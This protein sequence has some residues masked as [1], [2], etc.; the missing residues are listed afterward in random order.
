MDTELVSKSYNEFEELYQQFRLIVSNWITSHKAGSEIRKGIEDI[1]FNPNLPDYE[2][3]K[4]LYLFI[5]SVFLSWFH[6]GEKRET[7]S[8]AYYKIAE[9]YEAFDLPMEQQEKVLEQQQKVLQQQQLQQQEDQKRQEELQKHLEQLNQ[10][11]ILPQA[12][13]DDEEQL[14]SRTKQGR[15]QRQREQ[16]ERQQQMQLQFQQQQ[17]EQQ[18]LQI[19]QQNKQIQKQ[20]EFQKQQTLQEQQEQ[21]RQQAIQTQFQQQLKQVPIPMA[22]QQLEFDQRIPFNSL[23]KGFTAGSVLTPKETPKVSFSKSSNLYFKPTFSSNRKQPI[24]NRSQ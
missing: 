11:Q 4:R 7:P 3:R 13:L 24:F 6:T 15:D 23:N 22:S 16:D 14:I 10:Q 17:Q 8:R 12:S 1:I 18:R 5:S 9:A 19:E 2:K 21:Q 20:F